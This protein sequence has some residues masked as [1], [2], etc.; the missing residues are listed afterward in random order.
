MSDIQ[1]APD[2]TSFARMAAEHI[3]ALAGEAITTNGRFTI[4]LSGGNTPRP[5]YALLATAEL[6]KQ[7]DWA[8]VQVFFG[9]ERCVP[10]D[11]PESNYRMAKE[12]LLDH[13]PLPPENVHRMRGEDDPTRAATEY[14]QELQRVFGGDPDGG[15]PP[16]GFDL[17]LLGMGDNGHTASL[18]PG[19]AAIHEQKR[20]VMA[21]YAE[22][23]SMWRLT[24]TPAIINDATQV[25]FLVAGQ[26]KADTLRQVLEGPYQPDLLPAQVVKPTHGRLTWLL[27]QAAASRLTRTL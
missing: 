19:T 5:V 2:P 24:L 9:D 13:V 15:P 16:A 26:A 3:A 27:D 25:T 1:V 10:P 11:H 12:A 4:A 21:V 20:W 7:I 8:S 17:I 6:A 18:F 14:G 22:A 23:V